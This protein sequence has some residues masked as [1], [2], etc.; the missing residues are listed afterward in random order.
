MA[1]RADSFEPSR[2][3]TKV[4]VLSP[5]DRCGSKLWAATVQNYRPR[6]ELAGWDKESD[7]Q[8]NILDS[9]IVARP[10]GDLRIAAAKRLAFCDE[11]LLA[12]CPFTPKTL[13]VNGGSTRAFSFTF[14]E[15]WD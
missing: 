2:Q 8:F 9:V 1:F 11:T 12:E 10:L 3:L 5:F 14:V 7:L 6:I 13:A 15:P 4:P